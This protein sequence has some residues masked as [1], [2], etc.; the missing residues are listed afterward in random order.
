MFPPFP[1]ACCTLHF[2]VQTYSPFFLLLLSPT[3]WLPPDLGDTQN[4]KSDQERL[5][6]TNTNSGSCL[7]T[8]ASLRQRGPGDVQ[9][10]QTRTELRNLPQDFLDPSGTLM[11][12]QRNL[13]VRTLRR[14]SVSL[15]NS[16]S[17]L[18]NQS[19]KDQD[20]AETWPGSLTKPRLSS[21][22]KWP[23]PRSSNGRESLASQGLISLKAPKQF[24]TIHRSVS[25]QC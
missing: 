11:G 8:K 5:G 22:R 10:P 9:V 24:Q 14:F 18:F 1:T 7:W 13:T 21:P 20:N 4:R 19:E 23:G 16:C 3:P 17:G 12:S 25:R 15:G 6:K 2:A